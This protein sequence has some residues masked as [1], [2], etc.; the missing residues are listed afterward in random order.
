M[1]RDGANNTING[2]GTNAAAVTRF[3]EIPKLWVNLDGG[4]DAEDTDSTTTTSGTAI[5]TNARLKSRPAGI[6]AGRHNSIAVT[7]QGYPVI[8]YQAQDAT[9]QRVK[10]AVSNSATPYLAN[11]WAIIDDISG[12]GTGEFVSIKIDTIKSPN[13]VHIA[14]MNTNKRLVYITFTLTISTAKPPVVTIGDYA[15]Q[16]V[17]SVG[18]V[19]R[20][21]SLSLDEGGNPWISYMDESYLGARD[22]VK[23][24]YKNTT[25][26][27]KGGTYRAGE[28]LD[29]NGRDINGWEAMHVPTSHRVENPTEGPGRE[30]G[31]LGME[32]FPARNNTPNSNVTRFWSGA[33]S[34][35]SQDA[36]MNADYTQ[37]LVAPM[38]RYR[39]A[40]Y[41]K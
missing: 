24:A 10:L 33:V 22:G 18:N 5:A 26:F 1:T 27:Y 3:N 11:D 32:C 39:I 21:C 25:T 7:S 2:N 13:V 12:A 37:Q 14:A 29:I 36:E 41:V 28:D 38:D 20:W 17:D 40:Y 6:K 30:H 23:V 34:Y 35:L 15:E 19:G 31:R 16:V 9:S 8:A 4:Y